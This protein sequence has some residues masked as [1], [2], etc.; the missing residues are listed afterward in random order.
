MALKNLPV[1][2]DLG[3]TAI[4][5]LLCGTLWFILFCLVSGGID[6]QHLYFSMTVIFMTVNFSVGGA[7]WIVHMHFRSQ[8]ENS[9]TGRAI[10]SGPAGH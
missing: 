10:Q 6:K 7:L 9:L 1:Y 5:N 3:K 4:V 2:K 8:R